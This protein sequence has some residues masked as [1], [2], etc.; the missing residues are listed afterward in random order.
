MLYWA[1]NIDVLHKI[2]DMIMLLIGNILGWNI[3]NLFIKFGSNK[4]REK[5]RE[6]PFWHEWLNIFVYD[7]IQ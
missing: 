7:Y 1:I 4:V 2:I 6:E 3:Y 5:L